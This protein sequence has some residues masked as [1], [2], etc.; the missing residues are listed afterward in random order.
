MKNTICILGF[1]LLH[2]TTYGQTQLRDRFG[3]LYYAPNLYQTTLITFEG[4]PYL[5]ANFKPAKINDI[6]ETI[7]VRFD[8]FKEHVEIMATGSKVIILQDKTPYSIALT[9][10]SDKIYQT[11]TY[12]NYEGSIKASFFELLNSD[13]NYQLFLKEKIKLYEA[14]KA[15]GYQ[16]AAPARFKKMSPAF[17]FADF[18]KKSNH[19]I[20]LPSKLKA[21]VALFPQQSKLMRKFI[22][23]KRLKLDAAEDLIKIF[24]FYF[25][26]MQLKKAS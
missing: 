3:D 18:G 1:L 24:D 15:A 23:D 9:D 20:L 12:L 21:F 2:G 8:A 10:G 22:K 11:K 26:S 7:W 19:L 14:V 25:D 5:T 16:A 4:S 13:Q 17:Y 6:D